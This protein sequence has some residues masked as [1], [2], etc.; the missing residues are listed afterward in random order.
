VVFS[1]VLSASLLASTAGLQ[2]WSAGAAPPAKACVTHPRKVINTEPKH[3]STTHSLPAALVVKLNAAA[4]RGFGDAATPGAVV[5]VRTRQGTWTQAYGVANPRTG[6]PM[7]VGMHTRIGSVTKT[8]TGTVLLRLAQKGRLSLDDPIAKYVPGVPNGARITLRMLADMTSGVASYTRS[9]DFTDLY[10]AHPE[11]IF[12]PDHLL[13]IGI[14][15]SPIFPPGGRFDYSNTNTVLLGK[16]IEK[17]TGEPIGQIFE[18]RVFEPLGMAATSW[19]GTRTAIPK[20]YAQGFTL[21]GDTATPDKPSNATHWNPSF[22][23]TAGEIISTMPDLLTYGRALGTGQGLLDA[24]AQLERLTSF[25]SPAGY[26]IAMGC[27]DGWVGHGGELPGYNTTVFY[28]TTTDTTVIVQAN[29]D[30]ASG[31]C[32]QSPTLD[33]NPGDLVCASPA[34]RIFVALSRALGHTFTPPP[35]T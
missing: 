25:P 18:R 30:I 11:T 34:T 35:L 14:G 22:G 32:P 3:G 26:G 6:K 27:V 20:P 4:T 24:R 8:V 7:V 12:S 33:D 19:P 16:V 1:V 15:L 21:Q 17:V 28:D 29:S 5:G 13:A 10:F 2:A 9:T 23:W 31:N